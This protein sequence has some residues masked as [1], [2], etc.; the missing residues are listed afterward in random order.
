[1]KHISMALAYISQNQQY[2]KEMQET[3]EQD[4]I[5]TKRQEK[6]KGKKTNLM[7]E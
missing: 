5:G 4:L 6:K 1:M 7:K 3:G 2:D